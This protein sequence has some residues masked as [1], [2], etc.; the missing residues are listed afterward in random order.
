MFD[1]AYN[2]YV[3][4]E[5]AGRRGRGAGRGAGISVTRELVLGTVSGSKGIPF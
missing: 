3:L 2:H 5:S 1:S 4:L